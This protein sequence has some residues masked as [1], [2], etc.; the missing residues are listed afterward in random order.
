[1]SRLV[2]VVRGAG[3]NATDSEREAGETGDCQ[4]PLM[5]ESDLIL[6]LALPHTQPSPTDGCSKQDRK[7]FINNYRSLTGEEVGSSLAVVAEDVTRTVSDIVSCLG[8]RKAVE[9]LQQSIASHGEKLGPLVISR[10]GVVSVAGEFIGETKLADILSTQLGRV[11]KEVAGE[12]GGGG[13]RGKG[14]GR[15]PLHSLD[16]KKPAHSINW[17]PTWDCMAQKCRQE[18]CLLPFNLIRKHLDSFLKRHKFCS[19]CTFSVNRAFFLLQSDGEINRPGPSCPHRD[20][21]FGDF[22]NLFQGVSA[23]PRVKYVCLQCDKNFL[24]DLYNLIE[25]ELCGLSDVR[26]AMTLELAQKELLLVIGL[27]IFERFRNIQLK[28]EEAEQMYSLLSLSILKTIRTSF[29]MAADKKKGDRDIDLLC[30]ELEMEEKKEERKKEKKKEKKRN[31]RAKKKE[32]TPES[33]PLAKVKNTEDNVTSSDISEKINVIDASNEL[34]DCHGKIET[35]PDRESLAEAEDKSESKS[36]VDVI[37]DSIVSEVDT[38]FSRCVSEDI[39]DNEEELK[40]PD[41]EESSEPTCSVF[42]ERDHSQSTASKENCTN[43]SQSVSLGWLTSQARSAPTKKKKKSG[44]KRHVSS[45]SGWEKN[46]DDSGISSAIYSDEILDGENIQRRDEST[47]DWISRES[48]TRDES[49]DWISRESETRDERYDWISKELEIKDER[50]DWISRETDRRNERERCS[51]FC[52][53]GQSP[54]ESEESFSHS[55]CLADWLTE[56]YVQNPG[57]DLFS[58]FFL[59]VNF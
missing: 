35:T 19:D 10:G 49:Y 33:E 20:K 1:M 13:K 11:G 4:L 24:T 26:H 54:G 52:K 42:C 17:E 22:E 32:T 16:S 18:V 14:R 3:G 7:T 44:K 34:D 51:V 23:C 38:N 41:F 2:G 56:Q 30:R 59:G 9:S 15:C 25:P 27:T 53:L 12:E 57:I 39:I 58:A 48:E 46:S 45:S 28:M 43:T 29:D 6:T 50:D 37:D 55:V 36:L 31:Q 5:A 8:C 40:M 47:E 21:L